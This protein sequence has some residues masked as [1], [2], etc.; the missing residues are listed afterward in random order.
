MALIGLCLYAL[1]LVGD[2]GYHLHGELR[3]IKHQIGFAEIS[4]AFAA[5]LFWPAD[6]LVAGLMHYSERTAALSSARLRS[7]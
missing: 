7:R 1:I 2:A 6:L 4:V 3:H 5:G